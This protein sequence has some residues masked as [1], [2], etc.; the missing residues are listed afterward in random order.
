ME[1]VDVVPRGEENVPLDKRILVRRHIRLVIEQVSGL[2]S[3]KAAPIGWHNAAPIARNPAHFEWENV[4]VTQ[5]QL[6]HTAP[7]ITLELRARGF[8]RS[9]ESPQEGRQ[10]GAPAQISRQ[11]EGA[12][13][14]ASVGL[15]K[16]TGKAR[17]SGLR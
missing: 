1:S 10:N 8:C 14:S 2:K 4:K 7:K 11:I 6:R 16:R 5:S 12:K 15:P 13:T 3:R 17:V 9:T